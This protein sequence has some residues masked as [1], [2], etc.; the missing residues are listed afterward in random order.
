[1]KSIK[2]HYIFVFITIIL[3]LIICYNQTRNIK[4][5]EVDSPYNT[6]ILYYFEKQVP[7]NQENIIFN[8]IN[9]K[10]FDIIKKFS[11]YSSEYVVH[12]TIYKVASRYCNENNGLFF[13]TDIEEM[14]IGNNKE[15]YSKMKNNY[16][17]LNI[18]EKFFHSSFIYGCYL[19]KDKLEIN[20]ISNHGNISISWLC[21][22]NI[23]KIYNF[24]NPFLYYLTIVYYYQKVEKTKEERF[25]YFAYFKK[26]NFVNII[27]YCSNWTLIDSRYAVNIKHSLSQEKCAEEFIHILE[28][29]L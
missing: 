2:K 16:P 6:K 25:I 24:M 8:E 7:F 14:I 23:K 4:V 5:D 11:L 20:S 19:K 15:Q 12:N 18:L 22:D 9:E 28:E 13:Q 21:S 26:E 3:Y 10:E 17:Q 1:M 27:Q 29:I